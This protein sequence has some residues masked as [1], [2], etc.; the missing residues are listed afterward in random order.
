MVSFLSLSLLKPG[1][2]V[3]EN[4]TSENSLI[5]VQCYIFSLPVLSTIMSFLLL[6]DLIFRSQINPVD[7]QFC[8]ITG[9]M[10]WRVRALRLAKDASVLPSTY[11]Q[12][13]TT[14]L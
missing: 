9:E 12:R 14:I 2:G 6:L 3:Q 1:G 10:A 7:F 13:L 11:T 8:K 4:V 5:S